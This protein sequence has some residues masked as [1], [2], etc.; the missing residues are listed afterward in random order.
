EPIVIVGLVRVGDAKSQKC[1]A[2]LAAAALL[3]KKEGHDSCHRWGFCL[4]RRKNRRQNKKRQNYPEARAL[5]H[6][7]CGLAQERPSTI[8]KIK[9]ELSRQHIYYS[10]PSKSGQNF[11]AINVGKIFRSTLVGRDPYHPA[12]SMGCF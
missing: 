7:M 6:R 1:S 12:K 8:P 9:S 3:G 10:H 4:C 2:R 5:R 11:Y